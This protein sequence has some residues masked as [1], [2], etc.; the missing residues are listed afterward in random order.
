MNAKN[1]FSIL[2]VKFVKN[3]LYCILKF[4]IFVKIKIQLFRLKELYC[5]LNRKVNVKIKYFKIKWKFFS[6]LEHGKILRVY[7]IK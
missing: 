5:K 4:K 7:P 2:T 6:F 3:K 1:S